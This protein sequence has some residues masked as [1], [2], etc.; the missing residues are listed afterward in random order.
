VLSPN[1]QFLFFTTEN[2]VR[3]I[4]TATKGG[5]SL[6]ISDV[7]ICFPVLSTAQQ[8]FYIYEQARSLFLN[9]VLSRLMPVLH[10]KAG[11]RVVRNVTWWTFNSPHR[12][13]MVISGGKILVYEFIENSFNK[14]FDMP[15]DDS[16][17]PTRFD[18]ISSA[19]C[20]LTFISISEVSFVVLPSRRTAT[21]ELKRQFSYS[22]LGMMFISSTILMVS[23]PRLLLALVDLG[24]S[25][26]RLF[27][28]DTDPVLAFDTPKSLLPVSSDSRV[29]FSPDSLSFIVGEYDFRSLMK[30]ALQFGK[31]WRGVGHLV[32]AHYPFAHFAREVI[33]FA[34]GLNNPIG[35][36]QLFSEFSI[37][38]QYLK[39]EQLL[40]LRFVSHEFVPESLVYTPEAEV[41]ALLKAQLDIL[42]N[43]IIELQLTALD[44][45]YSPAG[46]WDVSTI[47]LI[48]V[49]L[50]TG[51][52]QPRFKFS[53]LPS[54]S[55]RNLTKHETKELPIERFANLFIENEL[56]LFH[57]LSN[58]LA[59]YDK[60]LTIDAAAKFSDFLGIV[61]QFLVAKEFHLPF[62]VLKLPTLQILAVTFFSETE[63]I[64]L[65]KFGLFQSFEKP[66]FKDRSQD[67]D[68]WIRS[69]LV[70]TFAQQEQPPAPSGDAEIFDAYTRMDLKDRPVAD[71]EYS[72][73]NLM[74]IYGT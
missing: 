31:D 20:L 59:G 10:S 33:N 56:E 41:R 38:F 21:I 58:N 5:H 72:I 69:P 61:L 36:F 18:V 62:H 23:V 37:G 11:S 12:N 66:I 74:A 73:A 27:L 25:D 16:V 43:P 26:L 8:T 53:C 54:V 22:Q 28:F 7:H 48:I 52:R 4:D 55:S 70:T 30:S 63:R 19:D 51:L 15:W 2:S 29:F 3:I 57:F 9:S 34:L 32:G 42:R 68:L 1:K 67:I 65:A 64:M 44:S 6:E 40:L 60:A 35:L 71:S 45:L 39:A 47:F 50:M 24:G 14:C 17:I 46:F 49:G 13:L